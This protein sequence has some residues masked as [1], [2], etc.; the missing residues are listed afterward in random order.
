MRKPRIRS[1]SQISRMP[2]DRAFNR[3]ALHEEKER[4]IQ[5]QAKARKE[6]GKKGMIL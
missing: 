1:E 2:E 6:A 3:E 5:R 4:Y